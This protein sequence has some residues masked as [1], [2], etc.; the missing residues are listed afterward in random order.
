[1]PPPPEWLKLRL[2][3]SSAGQEVE[4]LELPCML[5]GDATR[6][7]HL[8]HCLATFI[9]ID[10]PHDPQIPLLGLSLREVTTYVHKKL[11]IKQNRFIR[12]SQNWKQTKYPPTGV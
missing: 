2:T 8:E 12:N 1:M 10:L 6:H 9:N 5:G 4:P 7:R 11:Y 3:T